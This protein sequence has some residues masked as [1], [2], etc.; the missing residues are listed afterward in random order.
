LDS[1]KILFFKDRLFF[2]EGRIKKDKMPCQPSG[3][4]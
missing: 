3:Y 4:K 1:V 2:A